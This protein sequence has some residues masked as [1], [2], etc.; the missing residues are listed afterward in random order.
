MDIGINTG[1]VQIDRLRPRYGK[2]AWQLRVQPRD[3]LGGRQRFGT[4]DVQEFLL[5]FDSERQGWTETEPWHGMKSLTV[6]D[7]QARTPGR[8]GEKRR[9]LFGTEKTRLYQFAIGDPHPRNRRP[10]LSPASSN[11]IR[12]TRQPVLGI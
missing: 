10:L 8:P 9:S 5:A 4:I 2:S 7:W 3:Q 6:R 11:G 12:I 1:I